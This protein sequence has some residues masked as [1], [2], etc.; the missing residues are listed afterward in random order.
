MFTVLALVAATGCGGSSKPAYCSDR[1]N[2]EQAVKDLPSSITSG[3]AS[4]LQSQVTTIE[5]D[6]TALADAAKSDFP[7][8][9]SAMKS[10]IESLKT[11]VQGLPSNPSTSDLAAIALDAT[12]AVNAVKAFTSATKSKCD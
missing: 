2:L 4:G 7:S 8:E 12:A 10:S 5:S 11:E 6:A 9:T 1:S 3:G